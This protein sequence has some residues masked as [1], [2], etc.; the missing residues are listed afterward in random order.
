MAPGVGGF[1]CAGCG[2]RGL[3]GGFGGVAGGSGATYPPF[4][5]LLMRPMGLIGEGAV[6]VVGGAYSPRRSGAGVGVGSPVAG[7]SDASLRVVLAGGL[8]VDGERPGAERSPLRAGQPLRR[9]AVLSRRRGRRPDPVPRVLIGVAA[10]IKLTPLLFIAWLAMIGRRRDAARAGC[11]F[12]ACTEAVRYADHPA[13][14][15]VEGHPDRGGRGEDSPRRP[16]ALLEP[17]DEEIPGPPPLRPRRR[18]VTRS[19]PT[20]SGPTARRVRLGR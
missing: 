2:V 16:A 12:A 19:A 1:G 15:E 9:V 7:P 10:A 14:V 5:L 13:A 8:R 3:G 6:Q 18:R 11:S 17:A 4:A 20:R